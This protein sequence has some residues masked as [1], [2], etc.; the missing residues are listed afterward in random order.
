MH[1]TCH[2]HPII[3]ICSLIRRSYSFLSGNE[4]AS[5]YTQGVAYPIGIG[6]ERTVYLLFNDAV[7]SSDYIVSNCKMISE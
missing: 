7:S 1:A 2:T 6:Q 5:F 3:L 4:L